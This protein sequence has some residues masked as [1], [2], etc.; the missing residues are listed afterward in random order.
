MGMAFLLVE[1]GYN[2]GSRIELKQFPISIGRD[3]TNEVVLRDAEASRHHVRIKK[4]GRLFILEDL[5]SRNG[6]YINGDRVINSTLDNGDRILIGST[7][8]TFVAPDSGIHIATDLM[9]FD[10]QLD[11]PAGIKGPIEMENPHRHHFRRAVRLDPSTLANNVMSNT[12]AISDIFNY[13]SNL[14]VIKDLNESCNTLLKSVGK[15]IGNATR[16][17]V[18]IWSDQTRQLIPYAIKNFKESNNGFLLSKS[19]F[20][21]ALSRKQGIL[22][23]PEAR[24]THEGR[25][26]A[27]LPVCHNEE[28]IALV[29]IEIDSPEENFSIQELETTQALLQRASPIIES[30]L[31]RKELDSWLFG[32]IDTMMS[33]I[34]AKDTYTRGH[35]ERVSSYAMAIADEMKLHKDVKRLLMISSLCHDIGK[36]GIPDA[37]LKKAGMLSSEEYAEMKLHPT[38]GSNIIGHLPNAQRIISG[39]KYHHE[40]W[41]GTGYP[42]GLAGEDIPF[43]GRIVAISDVFD[44]MVSGRV[45]S[46]FMDQDEAVERLMSE[47]DLFD[48]EILK[49]FARACEKGTLSLKTSTQNNEI[50]AELNAQTEITKIN[51]R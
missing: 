50:D 33:T 42:E 15:I 14:I 8:F 26:R 5:E 34:E 20:E 38:I 49:A 35:S 6:T 46:G 36:I 2:A 37:I 7:E 27:I 28:I 43:F 31:L 12:Q 41:D 1:R 32:I 45:Y 13:H 51:K 30:M 22:L 23:N 19:A 25:S 18:F 39:I 16:A 44:A 47:S 17:A 21:D 3:P 4:R 9:R 24:V 48:P 10:M 29:H 40:K 11:E